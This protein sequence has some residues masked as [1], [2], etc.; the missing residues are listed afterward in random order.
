M[1]RKEITKNVF[2]KTRRCSKAAYLEYYHPEYKYQGAYSD[3][4]LHRS[5]LVKNLARQLFD[6]GFNVKEECQGDL[7]QNTEYR[8]QKGIKVI[9]NACFEH[10]SEKC[11]SD[12]LIIKSD[13]VWELYEIKLSTKCVAEH[14]LDLA[15]Q[16]QII[17][18]KYPHLKLHCFLIH[19]DKKYVLEEVLNISK[20]FK[21]VNLSNKA[22]HALPLVKRILMASHKVLNSN[23]IPNVSPGIFC[24]NPF[25][26]EFKSYCWKDLPEDSPL[27]LVK[28]WEIKMY[29]LNDQGVKLG[30]VPHQVKL[31]EKL[32]LEI[33]CLVQKRY[34]INKRAIEGYMGDIC[35][36]IFFLQIKTL[37]FPIPLFKK[38][39]PYTYIPFQ[40]SLYE[41]ASHSSCLKHK[42]FISVSSKDPRDGFIKSLLKDLGDNGTIIVYEKKYTEARLRELGR[43]YPKYEAQIFKVIDRLKDLKEPFENRYLYHYN[44]NGSHELKSLIAAWLPE[45]SFKSLTIPDSATASR[46]YEKLLTTKIGNTERSNIKMDLSEY[47]RLNTYGL[48]KLLKI[49]ETIVIDGS[50]E[51]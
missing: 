45:V 47:G 49:L 23:K 26:C 50:K 41:V 24:T 16:S 40:Y 43:I 12:I 4:I 27:N 11:F 30:N 33:D 25:N 19:I 42:D 32:W 51:A 34:V 8:I 37:Q 7:V 36:P 22:R 35:F 9:Y 3:T 5:E 15:F 1:N 29:M 44:Q 20:L 39:S 46:A 18:T 28:S 14:I 13:T 17:H 48:A 31:T 10:N 6:N 2:L 38:T 21:I